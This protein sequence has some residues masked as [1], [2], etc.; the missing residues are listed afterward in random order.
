[1]QK[2][3]NYDAV[4][5]IGEYTPVD[6]GGHYAVIKKVEETKSKAGKDMIVVYFDFCLPDKQANYFAAEFTNDVRP[7]KKW[8]HAGTVYILTADYQDA[9]KP[10]RNFKTFCNAVEKSNSGFQ[11]PWGE[12]WGKQFV[13]KK[14]GVVFG[15]VEN[16]YNGKTSMRHEPRWFCSWDKV[17]DARVPNPKLLPEGQKTETPVTATPAVNSGFINVPEGE[18][19]DTP[20]DSPF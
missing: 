9:T 5:A 16:F 3:Q 17:K 14:I 8:P 20:F 13:N 10:S 2:F 4:N 18:T 19:G 15:E 11:I 12:A 6:L 1:M 7:E